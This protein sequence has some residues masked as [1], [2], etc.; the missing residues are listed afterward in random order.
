MDTLLV[1]IFWIAVNAIV[2]YLIGVRK[3][4]TASCVILSVLFGP[5]GWLISLAIKGD[6]RK[7]PFC[8]E[9]IKPEAKVCRHCGRDMPP[10]FRCSSCGQENDTE[11]KVCRRC[12][13]SLAVGAMPARERLGNH[14]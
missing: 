3:N 1:V 14:R 5:L 6:T 4:D 12:G 11:A 2:G 8:A 9:E 13:K 7:C 10:D